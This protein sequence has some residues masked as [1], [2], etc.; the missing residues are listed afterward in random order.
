MRTPEVGVYKIR[1]AKKKTVD[2]Q[3]A[4]IL[5]RDKLGMAPHLPNKHTAN[6]SGVSLG[7]VLGAC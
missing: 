4:A 7:I 1:N 2:R 5:A 3:L 6:L